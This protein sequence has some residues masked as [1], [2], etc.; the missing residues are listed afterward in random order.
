VIINIGK[1]NYLSAALMLYE[2]VVCHLA[3]PIDSNARFAA[4]QK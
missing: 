3:I 2:S 1:L 4:R